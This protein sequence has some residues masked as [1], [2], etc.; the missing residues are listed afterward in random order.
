MVSPVAFVNPPPVFLTGPTASGKTQVGLELA[1]RLGAEIVSMDSMAV[2]RFMNIGTAKPTPEQ[3]R[4]VPHHLVDCVDPWE[5]FSLAQYV[6]KAMEVVQELAR[7]GRRALFVGGTALYLKALLSGVAVG[8]PPDAIFRSRLWER[9]Q[10]E[11]RAVLHEELR[12]VDP[13]AAARIHPNDLKRIVRA[14]EFYHY[15]GKPI[16]SV[17]HHFHQTTAA[18]AR[19]FY[20]DWPRPV[21]YERISR[22]IQEMFEQGW[23]EEVRQLLE[24]PRPLSRTARMAHGYRPLMEYLQGQRSLEDAMHLT[25]RQIRQYAKRQLTWFRHMPECK[26]VP[27]DPSRTPQEVAEEIARRV[28]ATG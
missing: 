8:P 19:A 5:E 20:L 26:P 28:L 16:S 7:R 24:L 27:M 22:R 9:A 18:W 17:Q 12:R 15:T 2:Y 4:R 10:T 25:A 13:A 3:R 23:V 1:E 14:L 11:G 6:E 21:L